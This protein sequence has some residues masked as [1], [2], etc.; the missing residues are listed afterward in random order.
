MLVK[1]IY[2]CDLCGI[3]PAETDPY[4]KPPI[5]GVVPDI[6]LFKGRYP[7]LKKVDTQDASLHI[8]HICLFSLHNI[9]K[10]VID[11]GPTN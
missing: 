2:K 4:V 11:N 6:N 9:A 3:I 8:C 5:I 7:S 10:K 1:R